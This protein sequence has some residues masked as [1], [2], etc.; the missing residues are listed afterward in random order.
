[1]CELE[2]G[3]GAWQQGAMARSLLPAVVGDR[4]GRMPGY[5]LGVFLLE[6]DAQRYSLF[7]LGSRRTSQSPLVAIHL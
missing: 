2:S 3:E 4:E 1:M 6:R 7:L 5:G